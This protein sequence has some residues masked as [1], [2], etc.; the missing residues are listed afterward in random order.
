MKIENYVGKGII[1]PVELTSTGSPVLETGV[2][3][4]N[5]SLKIILSWAFGTRLF[6]NQFGNRALTLIEEPNDDLLLNL[7]EHF[8]Y[9]SITQ[10]EKRID[11]LE[12]K[13]TRTTD[14]LV[15]IRI[16]YKVKLTGLED[17]F[18]WPFYTNI[19]Y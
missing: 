8:T 13:A 2:K 16:R 17:T 12:L 15:S 5:S 6:L 18:V 3:L 14:T 4:I 1:F 11:I 10:W 7:A 19:I 9:D